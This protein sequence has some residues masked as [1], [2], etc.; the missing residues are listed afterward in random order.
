MRKFVL[1]SPLCSI[2]RQ[3]TF[4]SPNCAS[5]PSP[6]ITTSTNLLPQHPKNGPNNL[7]P[8]PLPPNRPLHPPR[9]NQPRAPSNR[10]CP[11]VIRHHRRRH[12]NRHRCHKSRADPPSRLAG[13]VPSAVHRLPVHAPPQA[14]SPAAAARVQVPAAD[15]A[16]GRVYLGALRVSHL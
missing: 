15:A 3:S 11:L 6:T 12:Q 1:L 10:R 14:H 7:P 16:G 4:S 5:T 9:P 8:P 2:A 13:R